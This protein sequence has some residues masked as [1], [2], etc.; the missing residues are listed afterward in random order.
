MART[1]RAPGSGG[2]AGGPA[3]RTTEKTAVGAQGKSFGTTDAERSGELKRAGGP[4]P[5]AGIQRVVHTIEPVF[6][7]RSRVLILGTM[8]SPKSREAA[9]YYA[10]P[11]NRFWKVM[12]ALWDEPLPEGREARRAFALEH[13]F[14]LWDTLASCDIRGAS[15]ASIANPVPNDLT[16]ILEGAPITTVFTTGGQAARFYRRFQRD[17]W[18]SLEH[19]ALPSTSAANA[20]MGLE[21]LIDA[22]GVVRERIEG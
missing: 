16:P 15:D 21:K 7:G 8:P 22:Y 3:D 1:G 9:F 4:I 11:Q 5:D 10:H 17:R 19:I 20:S 12:A 2:S 14:A 18:P 6:D 13:G